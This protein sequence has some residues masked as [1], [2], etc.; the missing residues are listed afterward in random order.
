M[1]FEFQKNRKY[2]KLKKNEETQMIQGYRMKWEKN[3]NNE[4]QVSIRFV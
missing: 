1:Q 2:V 4:N 3:C